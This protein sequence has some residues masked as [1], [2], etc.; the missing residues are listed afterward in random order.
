VTWLAWWKL[1]RD[2]EAKT[3][4]KMEHYM[5]HLIA[6][7]KNVLVFKVANRIKPA[8]CQLEF[9][10][11]EDEKKTSPVS[12]SPEQQLAWSKAVWAARIGAKRK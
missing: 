1:E 10:L 7:V 8:E 9:Q 6:A 3:M 5:T 12:H 2:N 11:A 4:T